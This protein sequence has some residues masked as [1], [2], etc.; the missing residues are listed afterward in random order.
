MTTT[1]QSERQG[2]MSALARTHFLHLKNLWEP[3]NLSPHY[4]VIRQAE[5]GLIQVQSRMGSTGNPFNIGD[6]TV[7]RSVIK[8]PGGEMGYSYIKGRNKEHAHLAA[9]IDALMQT[10][11]HCASL[12]QQ[13]IEPLMAFMEEQTKVRR[14]HIATSKVEFFTMVRGEDE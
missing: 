7:T 3:L 5:T 6:M 9:L 13:V 14:Q 1:T 11:T 8:L 12:K 4:Q 10:E 2:W